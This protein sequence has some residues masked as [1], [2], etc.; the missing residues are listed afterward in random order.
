MRRARSKITWA[1]P[2]HPPVFGKRGCKLLKTKDGTRKKKGKRPQEY[3][4]KEVSLVGKGRRR[5]G[6][7]ANMAK[8]IILVYDLSSSFVQGD[9]GYDRREA[10]RLAARAAKQSAQSGRKAGW[11]LGVLPV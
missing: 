11:E 6:S 7:R 2:P 5:I 4:S 1:R 8:V 10:L 9:L 3:R